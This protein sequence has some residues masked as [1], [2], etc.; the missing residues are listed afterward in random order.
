[1]G[2][3]PGAGG[4]F[5]RGGRVVGCGSCAGSMVGAGTGL[6]VP[7]PQ[8]GCCHVPAR[9]ASGLESA[10]QEASASLA[11]GRKP[12][13]SLAARPRQG[14]SL[15]VPVTSGG[16]TFAHRT[17]VLAPS[18][19][20]PDH[21]TGLWA[22]P[23]EGTEPQAVPATTSP[24]AS[25]AQ[26]LQEIS[27]DEHDGDMQPPECLP[28]QGG[29]Q[30]PPRRAEGLRPSQA[31]LEVPAEPS[32][33][34]RGHLGTGQGSP[35]VEGH[36]SPIL[37]P[38]RTAVP[39]PPWHCRVGGC[40]WGTLER[41]RTHRNGKSPPL[42]LHHHGLTHPQATPA[43]GRVPGEGMLP[44]CHFKADPSGVR[45]RPRKTNL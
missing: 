37:S 4:P 15:F 13:T 30:G 34:Q 22:Q 41:L 21:A 14:S 7:Q 18:S 32:Q 5:P 31:G 16:R 44:G 43:R 42:P 19:R 39:A 35:G 25:M 20:H 40:R 27:A 17:G 10:A 36:G 8:A 38:H 26:H 24:G 28:A 1:M 45:F 29:T 12:G 3:I 23:A 6:L 9:E 2:G 11:A 33:G